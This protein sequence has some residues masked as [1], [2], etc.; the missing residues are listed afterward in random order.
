MSSGTRWRIGRGKASLLLFL[1]VLVHNAEEALAYEA[2]RP[3]AIALVERLMPALALPSPAAFQSALLILV[4]ISALVFAWTARTRN[5][6]AAWVL[7]KAAAWVL[8]ANLLIPHLPAALAMG[9]Y[10]PGTITAVLVNLPLSLWIL[11]RKFHRS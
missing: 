3:R 1:A 6:R 9:G 2:S 8:L 11:A 10:A 5:E 4:A 7:L